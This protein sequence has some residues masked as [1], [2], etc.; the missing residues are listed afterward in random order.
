MDHL[1]K[2]C[3]PLELYAW[4]EPDAEKTGWDVLTSNPFS[5]RLPEDDFC[6]AQNFFAEYHLEYFRQRAFGDFPSRLHARLL[7]AT[8]VDAETFWRRHPQRVAGRELVT[9]RSAGDYTVSFHDA[10]WLDYLRLPHSLSFSR[11]SEVS[12]EYWRGTLAQ[13]L[14]FP[15]RER[16]WLETPIIEAV[17]QGTLKAPDEWRYQPQLRRWA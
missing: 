9:L 12:Q 7:F 16:P 14:G 13:E 4:L 2:D 1:I 10:S 3:T 8:R 15:F 6:A 17:F 11:L 5:T